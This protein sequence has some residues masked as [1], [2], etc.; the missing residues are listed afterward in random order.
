MS[1]SVR[2]EFLQWRS[3]SRAACDLWTTDWFSVAER[4]M[5]QPLARERP[6]CLAFGQDA[7]RKSAGHV[8]FLTRYRQIQ[9]D[10]HCLAFTS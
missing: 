4:E 8:A 5:L 7:L 2:R 3:G 1:S 6:I 9:M 10:Q